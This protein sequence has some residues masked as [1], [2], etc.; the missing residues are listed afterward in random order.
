MKQKAKRIATKYGGTIAEHQTWFGGDIE[1]LAPDGCHWVC[2]ELHALVEEYMTGF[3][4][5]A[6]TDLIDRMND[7]VEK[8]MPEKPHCVDWV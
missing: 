2:D 4:N 3:K 1:A 8:C 5:E 6:W 7:G